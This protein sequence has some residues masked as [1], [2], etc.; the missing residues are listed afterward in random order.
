MRIYI[1]GP[2]R[3]YENLN[4]LAFD[5]AASMLRIRGYDVI[6]PVELDRAY[7]GWGI[8]PP[9]D[10]KWSHETLVECMRRD[11]MA[12]MEFKPGDKGYGLIGWEESDGSCA[13]HAL[14]KCL[15]M[16]IHYEKDGTY[17]FSEEIKHGA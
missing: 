14:L 10:L 3:G 6:N 9:D 15:G 16:E 7:Y 5:R 4:F 1:F 2:M 13:E 8:F 12:I 11:L 17:E